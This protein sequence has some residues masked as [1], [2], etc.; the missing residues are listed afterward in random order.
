MRLVEN[1]EFF[2]T[3][4]FQNEIN[5]YLIFLYLKPHRLYIQTMKHLQENDQQLYHF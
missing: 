1:I 3:K 2:V 5:W 4:G